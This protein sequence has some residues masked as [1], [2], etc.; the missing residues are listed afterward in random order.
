MTVN[1]RSIFD[2]TYSEWLEGLG[3]TEA[4]IPDAVILEGSWWREDRQKDR[5][6]YL[7]NVRELNFPDIFWGKWKN[8]KIIFCMAYGAARA[9]EIS[10]I[11]S[12]LGCKLVIQIGTC[13]GLQSHL[14]PGDI[15]LPD[16]I[17]CEDGVSEHYLNDTKIN[18][19]EE[20]IT[21][22]KE[23]LTKRGCNVYVGKHVTFSSLFAETVE[24]YKSWHSSGFLSVEMETAATL[25]AAKKFG[26]EGL[27]IIVVWDELTAGRR[28]L[29]PL[30]KTELE[31]LHKSNQDVY[32]VAL[33][34]CLEVS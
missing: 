18:A 32:E 30:N 22:S 4:E 34:L 23:L 25:A 11:F 9:V 14:A 33:E 17:S 15:I 31:N 26:V 12:F 6:S 13:G 21:R 5:L 20:W 27:S 10:H 19:N 16:E 3:I 28:F 7:E 2:V 8:K 24:M 29:D 1:F